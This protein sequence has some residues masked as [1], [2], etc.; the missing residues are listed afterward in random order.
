MDD[1]FDRAVEDEDVGAIILSGE[2]KHFSVGHDIGTA[3][4]VAYRKEHGHER[5]DVPVVH[6]IV[7]FDL[8]E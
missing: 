5:Q 6:R 8:A 2:G 3:E 4:D 7:A 1:A